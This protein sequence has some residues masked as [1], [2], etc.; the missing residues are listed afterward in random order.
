MI[1]YCIDSSTMIDAGERYYPSDIFSSFWDKLDGLV[2]EGRLKAPET[3][4]SELQEKDDAWRDWVYQRKAKMI[5]DIDP[6]IQA[7]MSDAVMPAYT[8]CTNKLDSITGDLDCPGDRKH[9]RP[10]I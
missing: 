4:I 2:D 3:L 1:V 8:K 5:W 7:I 9:F 10:M 6:A